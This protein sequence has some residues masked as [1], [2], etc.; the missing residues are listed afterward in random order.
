MNFK[1]VTFAVKLASELEPGCCLLPALLLQHILLH[2]RALWPIPCLFSRPVPSH[3]NPSLLC[4]GL[5]HRSLGQHND[6]FPPM[7]RGNPSFNLR[8][9]CATCAMPGR[10]LPS[11]QLVVENRIVLNVKL[12]IRLLLLTVLCQNALNET[13]P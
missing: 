9:V 10:I 4:T 8:F 5:V 6:C 7:L 3:P 1:Q 11:E 12:G 2:T 13:G